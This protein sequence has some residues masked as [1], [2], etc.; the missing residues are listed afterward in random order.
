MLIKRIKKQGESKIPLCNPSDGKLLL[1]PSASYNKLFGRIALRILSNIQDGALLQKQA[2]AL[3]RWLFPQ[4][5][6]TADVRNSFFKKRWGADRSCLQKSTFSLNRRNNVWG[7]FPEPIEI[8]FTF[9]RIFEE[10]NIKQGEATERRGSMVKCREMLLRL[11]GLVKIL[12]DSPCM[13]LIW[14][15]LNTFGWILKNHRNVLPL[16]RVDQP[17]SCAKN[18]M[19]I[20][21][22]EPRTRHILN[23]IILQKR[24]CAFRSYCLKFSENWINSMKFKLEFVERNIKCG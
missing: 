13:R 6:S 22:S 19:L 1:R 3:R 23:N 20:Y 8:L 2:T 9:Y 21:L 14:K 4:K 15:L 10:S 5:S 24:V 16:H 11:E 17:V 18:E 12:W 7:S